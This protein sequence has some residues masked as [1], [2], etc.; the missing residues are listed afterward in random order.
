MRDCVGHRVKQIALML[1]EK[2]EMKKQMNRDLIEKQKHDLEK[3]KQ[4]VA[5]KFGI[6]HEDV[7]WHNS[8]VCYDRVIVRTMAAAKQVAEAMKGMTVNGGLYHG[9]PLGRITHTTYEGE[10]AYDVMC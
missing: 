5:T 10:G 1:K 2:G 4:W 3:T 8:G 9:M 7:C 6:R